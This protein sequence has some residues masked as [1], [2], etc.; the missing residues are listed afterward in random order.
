MDND[1]LERLEQRVES[2][3]GT[4]F[5]IRRPLSAHSESTPHAWVQE[6][7]PQYKLFAW[8]PSL[9]PLEYFFA[10][11]ILFFIATASVAGL[12]IFSGSTTVSTRNVDVSVSGPTSI[13]AGEEVTLQVVL[14]NRNVVPM[15]LTDLLVEFP[16]GTRSAKDVSIELPRQRESLGTI[17]PGASVNRTVKAVIFGD[18]G[19]PITVAV[20][21]EYRVPGSNA[22]FQ[23]TENYTA[24]ISQSPATITVETLSEVISGQS[25]EFT[26]TVTSNASENLTGMLLVVRYPP[27]FKFESAAP[28]P[29]SGTTVWNI[30]DIEPLG[31]RSVTVRGVFTGEDG[32]DRVLHVTAGTKKKGD[33]TTISA[34]LATTDVTLTVAKPFVSLV[35]A[36]NGDTSPIVSVDRGKPVQVDVSWANNLPV[37][38]QNVEIH[39]RLQGAILNKGSVRTGQGFYRSS[40]STVLFNKDTD[41]RLAVVGPGDSG[42]STF[43]FATFPVGQGTYQNPQITIHA[44]VKANRS[45]EGGVVDVLTSSAQAVLQVATDLTLTPVLS[46]VSGPL[47]PTVEQ[48]TVYSVTWLLQ[49]SANT[50]ANTQVTGVLPAYVEWVGSTSNGDVTYNAN[51][52]AITWNVGDVQASAS[53]SV[54][55]QISFTP[56]VTQVGTVPVLVHSQF[57]RAFDR[58]IR[59]PL[60]RAQSSITTQTSISSAHAVVVP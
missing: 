14:T 33:D 21:A 25:T 9:S 42:I 57:I 39:I 53:R 32:D 19:A 29:Y 20:T 31:K 36:L 40:D 30:G 28:K 4:E 58:F 26:V 44:T 16:A 15:N 12:L 54:T 52:R 24:T 18:T 56:S 35:L 6:P 50:I 2:K 17:E 1:A 22:V 47:P 49:N 51:D 10:A 34:P 41:S 43:E 3:A 11:S 46:R 60:E 5:T 48:T 37:R 55:Y 7:R 23:T 27:G 38:V 13:R 8:V 59:A 45:A